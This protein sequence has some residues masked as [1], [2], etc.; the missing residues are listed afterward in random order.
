MFL[1]LMVMDDHP[2]AYASFESDIPP[3][4]EEVFSTSGMQAHRYFTKS[5][6]M[7]GIRWYVNDVVFVDRDGQ[8]WKRTA[9]G[10]TKARPTDALL[11]DRRVRAGV[12]RLEKAP[13]TKKADNCGDPSN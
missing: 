2:D 4:T 12:L 10:L 9:S 7:V 5:R 8:A 13:T 6:N 11:G 3:R 1:D